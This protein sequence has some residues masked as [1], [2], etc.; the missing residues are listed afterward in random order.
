MGRLWRLLGL[1]RVQFRGGLLL[2]VVVSGRVEDCQ[3][4]DFSE[5]EEG[6]E[7]EKGCC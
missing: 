5:G 1:L 3:G 4:D 7:G 2:L 6:G